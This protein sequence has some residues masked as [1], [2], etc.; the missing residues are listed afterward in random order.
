MPVLYIFYAVS[1]RKYAQTIGTGVTPSLVK[2]TVETLENLE[3]STLT[4]LMEIITVIAEVSI[5]PNHRLKKIYIGKYIF[6]Y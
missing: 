4:F 3:Q 6:F 5:H 2:E 1:F